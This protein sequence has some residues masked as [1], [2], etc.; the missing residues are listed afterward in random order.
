MK[1]RNK[2][3][4]VLVFCLFFLRNDFIRVIDF[5]KWGDLRQYYFNLDE[6]EME[7]LG[8]DNSQLGGG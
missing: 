6:V 7:F 3:K 8:S 2:G 1:C 4:D 5:S